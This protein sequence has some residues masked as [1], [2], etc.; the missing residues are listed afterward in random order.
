MDTKD[1]NY[2]DQLGRDWSK[3]DTQRLW[4][5]HSDKVNG[6]LVKRWLCPG[7]RTAILKTDLFDEA[8]SA[9][10]ISSFSPSFHT[11]Y[12]V[13][14]SQYI[15][16]IAKSRNPEILISCGDIRELPYFQNR[17]DAVVSN[18]TLDHFA[19]KADIEISLREIVRVL[20]PGGELILTMDNIVNPIIMLRN[21][22]PFRWLN[23]LGIVPY[24]VGKTLGPGRLKSI[25][26]NMGMDVIGTEFVLH[27]PRVTMVFLA[28][29]FQTRGSL[30]FQERFL[31]FL[32]YFEK[33]ARWPTRFLTGHYIAVHASKKI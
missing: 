32:M 19:S 18:S 6:Q 20:R 4:R 13:D 10:F 28:K 27:C 26:E 8:C 3:S 30:K 23:R 16:A 1:T 2:W 24:F 22:L 25:L 12:G 29:H 11:V 15:A 7:L 17:F 9:G 33:L 14:L 5:V 31:N 21:L